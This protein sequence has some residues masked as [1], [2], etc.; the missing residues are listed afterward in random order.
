[1][2][3]YRNIIYDLDGTLLDTSEGVLTS[4]KYIEQILDLPEAPK[5]K[6]LT[7][8]GP[9]I[10]ETFR[11]HYGL[12]GERLNLAVKQFRDRYSSVDLL[13]AREYLKMG[14][15]LQVL[16]EEGYAQ[17]VATYKRRDYATE[18]LKHFSLS[19]HF[20]S[21]CGDEVEINLTKTE[22][23]DKCVRNLGVKD[24]SEVLM[25]GDTLSDAIASKSL[26]IDFAAVTY[27]FGFKSTEQAKE[28]G[29]KFVLS[30][31]ADILKSIKFLE[32]SGLRS[33]F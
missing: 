25:V 10:R 23:M 8:L 9:P 24:F 14:E 18:L 5:S 31:P 6:L 33:L 27:G 1:M 17:G 3:K 13:K 30:E 2:H 16:K 15:V 21:I 22:I 26:N 7:F 12:S 20:I 19:E 11:N 4:I 28:A 32:G 29:A